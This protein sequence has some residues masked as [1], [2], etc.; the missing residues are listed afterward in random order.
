MYQ[1]NKM[2]WSI[3]FKLTESFE[4]KFVVKCYDVYLCFCIQPKCID[5]LVDLT[6]D[7]SSPNRSTI[8][9]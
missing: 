2:Q 8:I 3:P 9:H 7:D 6:D 5:C 4:K 1:T